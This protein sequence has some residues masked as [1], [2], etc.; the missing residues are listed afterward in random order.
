MIRCLK[1]CALGMLFSLSAAVGNVQAQ[2]PYGPGMAY[3]LGYPYDYYRL[4]NIPFYA[5]YPPVYYSQPVPRTYGYSPFAYPPGFMT[6]EVVE[7]S[8]PEV[9]VNPH[10]PTKPMKAAVAMRPLRMVN[11]HVEQEIAAIDPAAVEPASIAL[12]ETASGEPL[13]VNPTD[14][15]DDLD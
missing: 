6:P 1:I 12:E 14:L 8:E 2:A 15:Y 7:P 13:A 11:P 9:M 4:Q 3:Y 10:V 5:L